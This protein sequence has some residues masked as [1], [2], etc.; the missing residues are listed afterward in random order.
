MTMELVKLHFI[1]VL[2]AIAS[3][4][5]AQSAQSGVDQASAAE[6]RELAAALQEAQ[7]SS[8]DM[9]AALEAHLRKYPETPLRM[10]IYKFLAKAAIDAKDDARLVQYGVPVLENIQAMDIN[11]LD[12]T[13]A[14]L[15]RVPDTTDHQNSAR[16]LKYA[17]QLENYVSNVPVPAGADAAKNREDHDRIVARTLLYQA[18]A[19]SRLGEH[20]EARKKAALAYIAYPDSQAARAWSDAFE[21]LGKPQEAIEHLAD[22][23]AIPDLRATLAERA[24]DRK[25]LGELYRKQHDGSEKGLGDEILAAYD[26]TSAAVDKELSQLKGVDPNLGVSDPMRFKLT[27][28]DVPALDLATL[29]NKVVI[30]DFWAT[31][32]GPCRAQHPLYEQ[33]KQRFKNYPDVVFLSVDTDEDT[34]LVPAFLKEQ[35]WSGPVYFDS[36]LVKLLTLDSIPVT[37]ISDRRGRMV[38]RMNGYQP[39]KF[40][41]QLTARIREIYEGAPRQ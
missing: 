15:L 20:D 32:C 39:D 28:L 34:G 1:F 8:M 36:G 24:A 38:S 16:A 23:F 29:R 9:I 31:W 35:N 3:T 14:A 2:F 33:V 27:G 12:R 11:L 10:D 4:T 37:M 21:Q 5:L 6:R 41:D 40:V 26:R 7:T 22:A 13:A 19:K 25:H 18:R 17:Q 30:F